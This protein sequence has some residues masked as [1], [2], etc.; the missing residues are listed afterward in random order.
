M[1]EFREV[2]ASSL[3]GDGHG[4]RDMSATADSPDLP[5]DGERSPLWNS[6]EA[7]NERN[8]LEKGNTRMRG[9]DRPREQQ[10]GGAGRGTGSGGHGGRGDGGFER[11]NSA[12]SEGISDFPSTGAAD[13]FTPADRDGCSYWNP[14]EERK[15]G[16]RDSDS[17]GEPPCGGSGRGNGAGGYGGGGEIWNSATCQATSDLPLA[18]GVDR[19][20]SANRDGCPLWKPEEE[21]NER[22][23]DLE[24][25]G[26]EQFG[27]GGGGGRSRG[28]SA[29]GYGG[30]GEGGLDIRREGERAH[31]SD[32]PDAGASNRFTPANRDGRPPWIPGEGRDDRMRDMERPG[33][34]EC[35][36]G[37]GRGR[38]AGGYDDRGD[39]GLE[40]REGEGA[41]TSDLPD[42]G[43]A[44]RFTPANRAGCNPWNPGQ[45]R[46]ERMRD[47]DRR[48]EQE[49][50]AAGGVGGGRGGGASGYYGRADSG[51]ENWN[52]AS[53]EGPVYVPHACGADRF[54]PANRD[55]RWNSWEE[56]QERQRDL[57]RR[58]E[59]QCG[60]GGGGGRGSGAGGYGG[61]GYGGSDRRNNATRDGTSVLPGAGA[62]D[63]FFPT[64]RDGYPRLN[65]QEERHE[66]MRDL[67]SPGGQQYGTGGRGRAGGQVFKLSSQVI[68]LSALGRVA[69]LGDLYD[70][71]TDTFC[72]D[73]G[74]S[75]RALSTDR[76]SQVTKA[77]PSLNV[78]YVLDDGASTR[79]QTLGVSSQLKLSI[80]GR[81]FSPEG[82]GRYLVD[83][84]PAT[85][86]ETGGV[87]ATLFCQVIASEHQFDLC[88]A[89]P[90]ELSR[91]V[92]HVLDRNGHATARATHFVRGIVF[93]ATLV[94][95]VT[96]GR[97]RGNRAM[98][99][100]DR[101]RAHLSRR[102]AGLQASMNHLEG[103]PGRREDWVGGGQEED[104]DDRAF[105]VR[106]FADFLQQGRERGTPRTLRDLEDDLR[107]AAQ[108]RAQNQ[109]QAV[110]VIIYLSPLSDVLH[111]TT[112]GR[113]LPWDGPSQ[114]P[115][116]PDE[117]TI[118]RTELLLQE[119]NDVQ[120]EVDSLLYDMDSA[121][122][123]CGKHAIN[124]SDIY[125]VWDVRGRLSSRLEELVQ[126][127]RELTVGIRRSQGRQDSSAMRS[128]LEAFR[129]RLGLPS[130][131]DLLAARRACFEERRAFL[132][133]L[134]RNGITFTAT[135]DCDEQM[136]E[137]HILSKHKDDSVYILVHHKEAPYGEIWRKHM[138]ML[139]QVA[140]ESK[141]SQA[142]GEGEIGRFTP[143]PRAAAPG[144]E[145]SRM[146]SGPFFVYLELQKDDSQDGGGRVP[147]EEDRLPRTVIRFYQSG[148]LMQ[149]DFAAHMETI[150]T[151]CLVKCR[152]IVKIATEELNSGQGGPQKRTAPLRIKCPGAVYGKCAST[153]QD[154]H[155]DECYVQVEYDWNGH[156][157]CNCG[158]SPLQYLSYLCRHPNHREQYMRYSPMDDLTTDLNKLEM[159]K[160]I[161]ILLLGETGVGKSTFINAF[162]NYLSFDE[163]ELAKDGLMTLIPSQFTVCKE[164]DYNGVLVSIGKKDD[165]EEA[166]AGKSC[167]QSCKAYL[168]N[169]AEYRIRLIDTPGIGDTRGIEQD[170]KNFDNIL[171]FLSHY[172][173]IHGICILLKP[174]NARLNVLFR[175]CI[176]E[177]LCHI[178]KSAKDN[179]AFVFTNARSTFY[180]PGDTMPPLM[181]MLKKVRH[182]PPHVD[183]E[184]SKQTIYCLDNESFRFLAAVNQ[185]LRFTKQETEDFARSWT[186]SVTECRR[187]IEYIVSRP[188]HQVQDT[189]SINE[190][191]RLILQ[192][193]MPLGDI[194][195]VIQINKK[196][197]DEKMSEDVSHIKHISELRKISFVPCV[198]L[199]YVELKQPHTVCA[200]D[201]CRE[202]IT[203]G[204]LA[205]YNY[206]TRCHTPCHLTNVE[207][208]TPNNPEIMSCWAIQPDGTCRKCGCQ[209]QF[210]MHVL[211]ETTLVQS[212]QRDDSVH[213]RITTLEE[214][215]ARHGRFI[216]QLKEKSAKLDKEQ[217][218]I[219]RTLARFAV[220]LK[221]NAITPYND[222]TLEYLRHLID[223]ERGLQ[224]A[225]KGNSA[226]LEG[227]TK[228]RAG[229]EEEVRILTAAMS[230][231]SASSASGPRITPEEIKRSVEQLFSLEINGANIKLAM[232]NLE[233]AH[234]N[235]RIEMMV[236]TLRPGLRA[237][238]PPGGENDHPHGKNH[239]FPFGRQGR[240]TDRQGGRGTKPAG[241]RGPY[242]PG[243]SYSMPDWPGH[244]GFQGGASSYQYREEP[245][246][247]KRHGDDF[248]MQLR[249]GTE[250]YSE[251]TRYRED[252]KD[253]FDHYGGSG[254]YGGDDHGQESGDWFG[255]YGYGFGGAGRDVQRRDVE[256]G[257][258]SY[259][260]LAAR[261]P[262]GSQYNGVER[263]TDALERRTHVRDCGGA[264]SHTTQG[265]LYNNAGRM[266]HL[267]EHT[268]GTSGWGSE[269]EG[270]GGPSGRGRGEPATTPPSSQ[271]VGQQGRS[272]R[273]KSL[274]RNR[275]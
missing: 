220:F 67:D 6:A 109:G 40:R 229:Y 79:F 206:K 95:S 80:L 240:S 148:V 125:C 31:T 230:D 78:S 154:W 101:L 92:E 168:F 99:S 262:P 177:L 259:S 243:G 28:S 21:R 248:G 256:Y 58:G 215:R 48:R 146:D 204:G 185:D 182:S 172:K 227:L 250:S 61:G 145:G 184:L 88:S 158:R 218:T 124:V 128:M 189:V 213:E 266:M 261:T 165:N 112:A 108:I 269:R 160:E 66:R 117:D 151:L 164:D 188:P 96:S 7:R 77:C 183:I 111:S 153:I 194:S 175:F 53:S 271:D 222:S 94:A 100:M 263:W 161:N 129:F 54:T 85:G 190:A 139:K 260:P 57:D 18:G 102:L 75:V 19:F 268:G 90:Q 2:S 147:D 155:C 174:N 235:H 68:K 264:S 275:G 106:I 254:V 198:D 113:R 9:G 120:A 257:N 130:L 149:D 27:G 89:S 193:A 74:Q 196:L 233:K 24:H 179:I 267:G 201:C 44:E 62:V 162:A 121:I 98:S 209:W 105:S 253:T 49:F 225:G 39:G 237:K 178:H 15:E 123:C 16:M 173:L 29:G 35:V 64:D 34:H 84:S 217:E 159:R 104:E 273:L 140:G 118:A 133:D 247:F 14:G 223:E 103:H 192:L 251:G 97:P 136:T 180:R 203:V 52:S 216:A 244:V 37:G 226:V 205:K 239:W 71:C 255:G 241:A 12:A 59:Q 70:I 110:P 86:G 36:G 119:L 69:R 33:E 32:L 56:Q 186:V 4:C 51:F 170:K 131:R 199:Q 116:H 142:H 10:D 210:H 167:T 219:S 245:L 87:K 265:Q 63:R 115:L 221:A 134:Q 144:S 132:N 176:N 30:R 60:S 214:A 224:D 202:V 181:E 258:N 13:R 23:R 93:G 137:L 187:L 22:M 91:E 191:R 228:L 17:P 141:S 26:E 45:E 238:K 270:I 242:K 41:R 5:C 211:H 127:V 72:Q 3:T 150:G 171:R 200:A 107:Y 50:G 25:P 11:R 122:R 169:Y 163:M 46:N 166:S 73:Y 207:K 272:S 8:A 236:W 76:F 43:A 143:G 47:S 246:G 231:H 197:I 65:Y 156:V 195:K 1:A 232:K 208:E 135:L 20:T 152:E 38:G 126:Q 212:Q 249:G 114:L 42:A 138:D 252:D 81:L 234:D 157:S 83:R 82:A 274:M 55:P